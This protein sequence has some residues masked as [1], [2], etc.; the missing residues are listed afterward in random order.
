MTAA[1][2]AANAAGTP[3]CSN[4]TVTTSLV[5]VVPSGGGYQY[6]ATASGYCV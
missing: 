2:A 1:Q 5:Y 6:S 4:V 3:F